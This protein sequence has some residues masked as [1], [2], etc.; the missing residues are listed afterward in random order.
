M[1][2]LKSAILVLTIIIF[3]KIVIVAQETET[4]VVDE[5]VAVVNNDVITLSRLKRETRGLVA[6]LQQDGKTPEEAEATIESKKGEIITNLIIEELLTQHAKESNADRDIEAQINQRLL[7]LM[8]NNNIKNLDA[9]Y[10]EMRKQGV[11]PEEF[12]ETMRQDL[13]KSYVLEREVDGKVYYGFTAKELK[14]YY[15]KNKAKFTK[16]EVIGL[17]ELFLGFAGRDKSEV[18]EK[19]KQIVAQARGG[20][21]FE[22]LVAENS[23]RPNAAETKGKLDPLPFT[24]IADEKYKSALKNAKVGDV[25]DPIELDEGMDILKVYERTPGSSDSYFDENAV[26]RALTLEKNSRSAS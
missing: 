12:R 13:M 25:L 21:D 8:K 24:D 1:K 18:Q 3:G 7:E 19:A 23:D 26:R 17:S 9:L 15:E 5:V 4:T 10:E 22:K 2:Y 14:D 20:A 6:S 11:D 16:P